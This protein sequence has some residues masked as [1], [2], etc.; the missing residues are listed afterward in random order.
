MNDFVTVYNAGK[1][2]LEPQPELNADKFYVLNHNCYFK[3]NC[4][5]G[6]KDVYCNDH[7]LNRD[8]WQQEDNNFAFKNK[9]KIFYNFF[10]SSTLTIELEGGEQ[11]IILLDV[12]LKGCKKEV[13][14]EM[15]EYLAK[16]NHDFIGKNNKTRHGFDFTQDKSYFARLNILQDIIKFMESK[17]AYFKNNPVTKNQTTTTVKAQQVIDSHQ[18]L[19]AAINHPYNW[20]PA[21]KDDA[22][23]AVADK[24]YRVSPLASSTLTASLNCFE[25][26]VILSFFKSAVS[27]LQDLQARTATK[28]QVQDYFK[29]DD[30]FSS[31]FFKKKEADIKQQLGKLADLFT[32]Q[33]FTFAA[34]KMH[35]PQLTPAINNK[36]HYLELF[37]KLHDWYQNL[38]PNKRAARTPLFSIKRLDKIYE[39]ICVLKLSEIITDKFGLTETEREFR[40]YDNGADI[41]NIL[42]VNIESTD[43]KFAKLISDSKKSQA[44]RDFAAG[45]FHN[46]YKFANSDQGSNLVV[47]LFYEPKIYY[48][49]DK[50]NDNFVVITDKSVDHKYLTPDFILRFYNGDKYSYIILDAKFS[51]TKNIDSKDFEEKYIGNLVFNHTSYS[52]QEYIQMWLLLSPFDSREHVLDKLNTDWLNND[53]NKAKQHATKEILRVNDSNEYLKKV[54]DEFEK[55]VLRKKD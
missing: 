34:E 9:D 44:Y 2:L 4:D 33:I 23:I 38:A 39:Y 37:H 15:L 26:Q 24:Y 36:P 41:N 47:E 25:N 20:H 35:F 30:L 45:G 42:G 52:T 28:V 7:K 5:K 29:L 17:A 32:K 1:K 3:F 46:Y 18:L 50:P 12:T 31:D 8:I 22:N 27:F 16:H 43:P 48:H 55:L 53:N 51:R 21:S 54:F 13:V 10:G 14:Q 6:I 49:E 11:H 19:T 40:V